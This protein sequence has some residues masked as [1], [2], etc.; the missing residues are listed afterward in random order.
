MDKNNN[1][2][3]GIRAGQ[4]DL[5]I[6]RGP[7]GRLMPARQQL[8]W[9]DLAANLPTWKCKATNKQQTTTTNHNQ[10]QPT[11]TNNNQQPP[12]QKKLWG[13]QCS[14]C[15]WASAS[16]L[17]LSSSKSC[18]GF[19]PKTTRYRSMARRKSPR[20][21]RWEDSAHFALLGEDG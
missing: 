15:R 18:G 13:G 17:P 4:A 1:S 5:S 19:P 10:P 12:F 6:R 21:K 16:R 2:H 11:T 14:A 20:A 8:S 9:Q 7:H 3:M